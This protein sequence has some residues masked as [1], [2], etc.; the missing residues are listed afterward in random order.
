KLKIGMNI[1]ESPISTLNNKGQIKKANSM[2]KFKKTALTLLLMNI[3]LYAQADNITVFAA[4]SFQNAV[5]EIKV[6]YAET[7]NKD[8]IEALYDSSSNL[9]RQIEQGAPADIFI[10]ANQS[11]MNYLEEKSL[12][13]EATRTNIVKK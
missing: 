12:I 5:D 1:D 10:S 4:A 9:A 2:N 13:D 3:G 8:Q 7:G 11:W 6:N